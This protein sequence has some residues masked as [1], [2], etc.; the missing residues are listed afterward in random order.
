MS[1]APK[2]KREEALQAAPERQSM[3]MEGEWEVLLTNPPAPP[4]A[5]FPEATPQAPSASWIPW[6]KALLPFAILLV[7]LGY[8]WS[9]SAPSTDAAAFDPR[10]DLVDAELPTP[11]TPS[12]N[13]EERRAL[14]KLINELNFAFQSR[15]W[16][17]LRAKST[18]AP[19]R[20]QA[21]HVVHA[22]NLL[23]DVAQGIRR[24]SM[25]RDIAQLRP[26]LVERGESRLVSALDIAEARLIV[27]YSRRAEDLMRQLPRLRV[28]LGDQP[29]VNQESLLLRVELARRFEAFAD[30][31]ADAAGLL[32]ADQVHLSNARTYY[33]QALRWLTT[34]EGWLALQ[35]IDSGVAAQLS[36]Q[37][38][39]KLRRANQRF[40]GPSIPFTGYDSS[41]WS[42]INGEP[43][44]DSPGGVW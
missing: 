43:L 17:T 42:G 32:T 1:E 44:H 35:P 24:G 13:R 26:Y 38:Q 34:R 31:E 5:P 10:R 40:H 12:L 30:E 4:T 9:T 25:V 18:A 27:H 20:V 21:D 33:Q 8:K 39:V 11:S 15:D 6:V 7:Y 3:E 2:S 23:A 19:L 41:T 37:V 36:Q 14:E 16:A 28:L 22:I 29:A